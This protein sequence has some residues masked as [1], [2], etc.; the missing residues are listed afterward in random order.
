MINIMGNRNFN[1]DLLR[2]SSAILVFLGHLIYGA[3]HQIHPLYQNRATSVLKLGSF[4]VFVFFFLSGIALRYQTEKYGH[5]RQW[6]FA[7][8]VRLMPMYWVTLIVSLLGALYF[9]AKIDYPAHGYALTFMG[10]QSLSQSV[11]IPPGNPPLWSLSV[12]IILSISLMLFA[13]PKVLGK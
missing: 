1:L 6:L 5:G 2:F 3:E 12:E 10:L 7:R 13:H 9:G 11:S 8:V 4:F